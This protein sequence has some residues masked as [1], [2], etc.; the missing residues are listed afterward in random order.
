VNASQRRRHEAV[1]ALIQICEEKGLRSVDLRTAVDNILSRNTC[2]PQRAE[3]IHRAGLAAQLHYLL[4]VMGARAAASWLK[5]QGGALDRFVQ[6][7][8]SSPE[9]RER[10]I[11]RGNVNAD[12]CVIDR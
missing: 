11:G 3:R 5:T 6:G 12:G 2:P 1:E 8:S 9:E 7:Y 4:D 10:D